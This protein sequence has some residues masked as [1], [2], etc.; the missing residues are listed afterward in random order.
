MPN[1]LGGNMQLNEAAA[2]LTNAVSTLESIQAIIVDMDQKMA[3]S[4]ND[5]SG[6][7][8]DHIAQRW[9]EIFEGLKASV[10]KVGGL[11][12]AGITAQQSNAQLNASHQ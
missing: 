4:F 10:N 11:L 6:S 8:R 12:N 1:D 9:V 7:A 3:S 2:F 5:K